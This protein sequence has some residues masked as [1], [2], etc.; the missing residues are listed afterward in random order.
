MENVD[1]AEVVEQEMAALK[2]LAEKKDIRLR[3]EI[4]D[5]QAKLKGDRGRIQSMVTNLIGNAIKFTPE[6]GEVSV[7]VR[8]K[9]EDLVL[10]VSDTGMGI[11]G[12]SLSKVFGRFYRV[13]RPGE[14]VHG[15]GL[16][17]AIVK[18]IVTMHGGR[19][20]LESEE[21]KGSTFSVFL[22]LENETGKT[23]KATG[24]TVR[25]RA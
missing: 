10:E 9:N 20:E 1:L 3:T 19:I 22:P 11:P 15:T 17:L 13:Y 25:A 23:H 7:S 5:R 4:R 6:R 16:G 18:E 24:E 14:H 2:P 8:R 21:G 12:D